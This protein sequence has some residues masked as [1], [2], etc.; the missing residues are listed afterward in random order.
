MKHIDALRAKAEAAIARQEELLGLAAKEN[1][2]FTADE[3]AEFDRLETEADQTMK[4]LDV[5]RRSEARRVTLTTDVRRS[6][7]APTNDAVD[8]ITQRANPHITSPELTGIQRIGVV[9]WAVAKQRHFPSKPALVHLEEAGFQTLANESRELAAQQKTFNTITVN[10]GDN[11]IVTP[12]STDFIETLRNESAFLSGGPVP[13]DLS[14]GKLDIPGGLAGATGTY[15]AENG[16]IGYTEMTTRKISL[17]AKHL[18][19][20]TA[21]GNYSISISPLAIASIVGDDLQ[22]GVTLAMDAAGLRGDGTGNNPAGVFTLTHASHKINAA[23]GVAPNLAAIDLEARRM[24]ALIRATNIPKRRRRWMMS[25]RVFTYLQFI[26]DGNGNLAFPGLSATSP[27]W[28]DNY[29]V[30]VT[31]QIPSNLGA[32]TNESEI[33]LTDFGHVLMGVAR[34]LVIASSTEASYKNAGGTLVSA[35]HRDET[36]LRATASHDFD[37]RHDKAAVVLRAVQ[38]G[39]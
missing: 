2:G 25:N 26:R 34:S 9:S 33:Y 21:I 17:A 3:Q 13:V 38:W 22:L 4:N 14:Y 37:M 32:G 1:R 12:L 29:P 16:E 39:A 36:V 11:A 15:G 6:A 30:T 8:L 35:F 28:Y 27:T 18:S 7:P 10:T 24:L 31:E 19:A 20:I 5:A 23:A